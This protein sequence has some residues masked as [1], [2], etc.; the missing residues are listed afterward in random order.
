MDEL[1]GM[2]DRGKRV[3]VFQKAFTSVEHRLIDRKV[4]VIRVDAMANS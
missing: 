3:E 1:I 2:T 4:Q